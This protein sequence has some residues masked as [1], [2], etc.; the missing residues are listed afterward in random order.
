M[1]RSI[2]HTALLHAVNVGGKGKLPMAD[3]QAMAHALSH[4]RVRIPAG[5]SGTARNLNTLC[6]LLAMATHQ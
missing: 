1:P 6:K 2:T 4:E 3:L 5:E